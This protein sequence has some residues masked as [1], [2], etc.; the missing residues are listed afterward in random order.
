ME[1]DDFNDDYYDSYDDN[2]NED[3]DDDN[4][5][6]TGCCEDAPRACNHCSNYGC[7]AHPC[8]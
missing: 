5:D 4:E 1:E 3:C 2:S 7:N 8:N 6:M